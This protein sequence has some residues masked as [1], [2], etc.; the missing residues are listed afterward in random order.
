[1]LNNVAI[2]ANAT[3]LVAGDYNVTVIDAAGTEFTASFTISEPPP[4]EATFET[5]IEIPGIELGTAKVTVEGGTPPY[6]YLWDDPG[7]STA[8]SISAIGGD[9]SV[10]ILDEHGCLLID[11]VTIDYILGSAGESF[12]DAFQLVPN[13]TSD[14]FSIDSDQ[15]YE[16]FE[17]TLVDVNGRR[18]ASWTDASTNQIFSAGHLP[19]GSYFVFVKMKEGR[20]AKRLLILD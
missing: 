4:L 9:Y 11:T 14:F 3:D 15:Y 17:V 20:F 2:G 6:S 16:N 18:M 1:M 19:N 7:Q 10:S 13:A 5:T 8:D 12:G